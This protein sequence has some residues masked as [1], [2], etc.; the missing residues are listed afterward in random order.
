MWIVTCRHLWKGD[1]HSQVHRR[2]QAWVDP[3]DLAADGHL[4]L[5][6]AVFCTAVWKCMWQLEVFLK[7][8]VVFGHERYSGSIRT[9]YSR[10]IQQDPPALQY[11]THHEWH[12]TDVCKTRFVNRRM[13]GTINE[14]QFG[15][16]RCYFI[17]EISSSMDTI[18]QKACYTGGHDEHQ[19]WLSHHQTSLKRTLPSPDG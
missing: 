10:K 5:P 12:F 15:H 1:Q 4:W 17:C 6:W 3:M 8:K 18:G 13:Y 2:L 16:G 19:K 9:S 11:Y 7:V 14:V